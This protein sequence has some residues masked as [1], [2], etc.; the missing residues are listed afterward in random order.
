MKCFAAASFLLLLSLFNTNALAQNAPPTGGTLPYGDYNYHLP[1]LE[2]P[3]WARRSYYPKPYGPAK[4]PAIVKKG[5]LA[6]SVEDRAASAQFMRSFGAGLVK[7]LPREL[8]DWQT[9]PTK[10]VINIRGGG[11]YYSFF[12]RSHEYGFGSDIEL[13]HNLFSVG[14]AGADYGF[15]T[16]L[17]DVPLNEISQNDARASFIANYRAARNEPDARCEYKRFLRGD[18]VG[19]SAYQRALPVQVNSTYLLRS[20]NYG[21]S[22]VLVAFRVIGKASDGSVTLAWHL[23]E[24]YPRPRFE[25]VIYVNQPD[26]KCPIK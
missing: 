4:E 20:I 25:R 13:D 16:N 24:E 7:L 3:L 12:Y 15:L 9:Y 1:G 19:G 10:K 5:L 8:F 23:L 21:R 26:N 11:A 18:T 17:G 22:D 6:P 14:F 2:D